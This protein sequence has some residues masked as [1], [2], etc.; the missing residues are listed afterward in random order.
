MLCAVTQHDGIELLLQVLL[1]QE[2][3]VYMMSAA[4]KH[5]LPVLMIAYCPQSLLALS[6]QSL[7][8]HHLVSKVGSLRTLAAIEACTACNCL[9]IWAR[10]TPQ[11]LQLVTGTVVF[12][13]MIGHAHQC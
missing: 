2:C 8:D 10:Q 13:C 11:Y 7:L 4:D 9:S 6:S 3:S 1:G 5:M 12:E